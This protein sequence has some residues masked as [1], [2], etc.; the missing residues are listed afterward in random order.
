MS[1]RELNV[2]KKRLLDLGKRNQ[3]M[4]YAHRVSSNLEFFQDDFYSFFDEFTSFKPYEV[5]KLF[6]N[7]DENISLSDFDDVVDEYDVAN[8]VTDA[9]GVMTVKKIRY[10]REEIEEIKARFER[11][12]NVNYLFSETIYSKTRSVLSLLSKKDK[13]ILEET[14]QKALYMAFGI[15]TYKDKKEYYE[16]PLCLVP[17]KIYNKKLNDKYYVVAEDDDFLI[18]ENLSYFLKAEY[19][20]DIKRFESEEF[21][22]YII[23]MKSLINSIGFKFE[24]R[25]A[26]GIFSFSKIMMYKD[27]EENEEKLLNNDIIKAFLKLD[28]NLDINLEKLDN[29]FDKAL[30]LSSDSSQEKAIDL[31]LNG[32]SFVLQGPPGTGKSQTITNMIASL[33]LNKKK[34]L[35]VCEKSEALEVVRTNLA[36]VN[37]DNLALC[38]YNTKSS[39]QEVVK[40]IYSNI[41]LIKDGTIKLSESGQ[42]VIEK[43]LSEEDFFRDLEYEL[44]KESLL[45]MSLEEMAENILLDGDILEFEIDDINKLTT[46]K[47]NKFLD[48]IDLLETKLRSLDTSIFESPFKGFKETRITK[49]NQE[50]LYQVSF[51]LNNNLNKL[52][53]Y[54]N[55]L[56]TY[57]FKPKKIDEVDNYLNLLNLS[58]KFNNL[59]AR[60]FNIKNIESLKEKTV[61]L[62]KYYKYLDKEITYFS[63]KYRPEFMDID[64]NED[65]DILKEK[66]SNSLKRL[67]GYNKF[68]KKYEDLLIK[69]NKM[70]YEELVTDLERL[71]KLIKRREVETLN[72]AILET[73]LPRLFF[74][75]KTDFK[76]LCDLIDYISEVNNLIDRLSLD[77][78]K[79]IEDLNKN[80][81]YSLDVKQLEQIKESIESNLLEFS[82]YFNIDNL[83]ID[84]LFVKSKNIYLNIDEIHKYLDVIKE[85][86]KMPKELEGLK[87][88]IL[89]TNININNLKNSFIKTISYKVF[90]KV[91]ED[92]KFIN[93]LDNKYINNNIN[94]FKDLIESLKEV[95]RVK[96]LESV[97]SSWPHVNSLTK[98]NIEISCL[99]RELNKKKKLMSVRNLL[100]SISSLVINLKPIFM[101]SPLTVSSFLNFDKFEFDCVIFDEA[102][103]ITLTDSLGAMARAKQVIVV[104]DKEQLPP[105]NFFETTVDDEEYEDLESVLNE[106]SNIL[107]QVSLKWHYRSKDESLINSS[108]NFIY[109]NL[110]TIP[111]SVISED[112][113]LTYEYVENGVY[114]AIKTYN[115]DEALKVV[116][117]LFYNIRH[118]LNKSIGIVTFNMKQQALINSLINKRRNKEK[119]YE[120]F[121]NKDNNFFV[122]NLETVQGD[123]KDIIILSTTFGY[124]QDHKLNMNF[125]PINREGG[126]RRLNV[127]ITRAKERL[128]VVSSLKYSDLE[129]KKLTNDGQRFLAYFLKYAEERDTNTFVSG[130]PSSNF[131]S[132]LGQKISE[133]GYKVLFN[134]GINSYKIDLAVLDKQNNNKCVLAI[135]TNSAN[136]YGLK[137]LKDRNYLIDNILSIRGFKILHLNSVY[138]LERLD[139]VTKEAISLIE[140]KNSEEIVDISPI[141]D[142]LYKE[143]DNL[144]LDVFSLFDSYPN[145]ISIIDTEARMK[146]TC[147]DKILN[148]VNLVSPISID[149]LKR[150]IAE[151]FFNSKLDESLS[152]HIDKA[153]S[154]LVK[155]SKVYKIIGFL[156]K[157]SDILSLHF[158]K[159]DSLNPYNRKIEHIYI[160]ELEAGFSTVISYVKQTTTSLLFETF[161]QLLGYPLNSK[162]TERIFKRCINILKD[163]DVISIEGNL[164]TYN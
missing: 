20:V 57:L 126:Y 84:E 133:Y 76:Y 16:A 55:K 62:S 150:L 148:I 6:T 72:E 114:E 81:D 13:L 64:P 7:L 79:T 131:I 156:I 164:I 83:T 101:M 98:T 92:N 90:S 35:F 97:T 96:T 51:N 27:I 34:I 85:L 17:V 19:K 145:I 73:S 159:Y 105:T 69:S 112:F 32:K 163:K 48:N 111:S 113:G 117:L 121:F 59:S 140:N 94:K 161:N 146:N 12:K 104:G 29:N 67:I 9:L 68:I 22:N 110:T 80:I 144:K 49:Q 28:N 127:A 137:S 154:N 138:S 123:E 135:L 93:G 53:S 1:N 120:D 24:E 66:Y 43:A 54:T 143:E 78:S 21:E 47:Y 125:G 41:E 5:A 109:H 75:K 61:S 42:N 134:I 122:K 95:S 100:S 142:D 65:I 130:E 86:N 37:L 132:V 15:V 10:E 158:R 26:L 106:A 25:I 155:E 124:N 70:S 160:E 151:P 31:A 119:N 36:K 30:V 147:E 108:N 87:N 39:K 63:S 118:S 44:H 33:A 82:N 14:G 23:R 157:P 11:K 141:S 153:I 46:T 60:D 8:T 116:D 129:A 103:Q 136:Y 52:I 89:N 102:S 74:G 38:L 2:L 58:N 50:K 71:N 152:A 99:T 88:L 4:N 40:S 18:N 128:I 107:P 149:E 3:L 162:E 139:L 45:D 91:F 115:Y 56:S 77:K